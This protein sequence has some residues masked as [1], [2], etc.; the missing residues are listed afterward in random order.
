MEVVMNRLT[1]AQLQNP[2][3]DSLQNNTQPTQQNPRGNSTNNNV[4]LPVLTPI[5]VTSQNFS[6]PTTGADLSG[7]NTNPATNISSTMSGDVDINTNIPGSISIP[8]LKLTAPIIWSTS[9]DNFETDLEQ[10]VIHYPGTAMPGQIGTTYIAGH[11]SNYVWAKGNY[12]HIFTDLNNVPN[13]ASFTIT[14]TQT[15]GKPAI[16]HYVVVSRQQFSPTDPA[17]IANT[18]KSLVALSTCWPINS[19]AKRLVLYGQLTQVE[20]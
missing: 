4:V 9:P 5:P 15:N 17:Q 11:S 18:G 2:S 10:G 12:N 3:A 20:Q 8:D 14:V 1:L 19:T 16:F 7:Q 6:A 13:N